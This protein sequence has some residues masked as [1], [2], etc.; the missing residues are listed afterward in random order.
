MTREETKQL[1]LK[2]SREDTSSPKD[3]IHLLSLHR[4][5]NQIYDDHEAQLKAK[6][7]EIERMKEQTNSVHNLMY[8]NG[9][10]DAIDC[11]DTYKHFGIFR[12]RYKPNAKAR[13]IVA[14]LFWEWRKAIRESDENGTSP[15][16]SDGDYWYIK[17][18]EEAFREAHKMIKEKK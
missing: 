15:E 17:A 12:Y 3:C 14:M 13:S 1:I 7:E 11:Y 2:A 8:R 9:Y 16:F 10:R 5:I 4:F 18:K 6:D